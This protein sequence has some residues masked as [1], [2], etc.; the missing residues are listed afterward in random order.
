M[1]NWSLFP[2]GNAGKQWRTCTAEVSHLRERNLQHLHAR[3][4]LMTFPRGINPL[5]LLQVC[6]QTGLWGSEKALRLTD[7]GATMRSWVSMHRND[8]GEAIQVGYPSHLL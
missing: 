3:C 8:E 1:G 5:P 6:Q 2:L 4:W 7:T